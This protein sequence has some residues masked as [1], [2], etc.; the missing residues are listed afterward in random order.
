M[1]KI[2]VEDAEKS[3]D[4]TIDQIEI[5]TDTSATDRIEIYMLDS[6]GDRVEGGTFSRSDF[7]THVLRFYN[8]NY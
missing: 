6:A 5:V 8:E 2:T 4:L 7:M 1:A 3:N